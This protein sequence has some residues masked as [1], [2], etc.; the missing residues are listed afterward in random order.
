V[1]PLCIESAQVLSFRLKVP[2]LE[3][4]RLPR[5]AP[6]AALGLTLTEEDGE[7]WVG[8]AEG[9]SGLRFRPIG[10]EA[11]LAEVVLQNDSGGA[12]FA[13]VL[14]SL[15]LRFAGDLHLRLVWSLPERNAQEGHEEVRISRGLTDY[16]GLRLP[17]AEVGTV[18]QA[19]PEG[20]SR[21]AVRGGGEELAAGP[22]PEEEEILELLERAR[23]AW[24]QYQRLKKG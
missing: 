21:N 2:I 1:T 10:A 12:F 22:S 18:A 11:M 17:P 14:G 9:E 15:M 13:Q 5:I 3:L 23:A 8:T 6:L 4:E 24:Q 19:G 7:L 20:P 16:P